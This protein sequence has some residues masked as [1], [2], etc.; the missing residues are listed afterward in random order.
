[1]SKDR[2]FFYKELFRNECKELFKMKSIEFE[3]LEEL[4]LKYGNNFKLGE[5]IRQIYWELKKQNE[6]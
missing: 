5:T 4:V 3:T 6:E 1:M 2:Y